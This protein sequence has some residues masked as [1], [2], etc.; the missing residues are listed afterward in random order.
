MLKFSY[1]TSIVKQECSMQGGYFYIEYEDGRVVEREYKTS[2]AAAH[3]YDQYKKHP[4]D[5]AESYGWDT[6]RETPTLAQQ[7]RQNRIKKFNATF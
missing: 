4:E 5:D 1:N 6:K 2:T 3:A 7:L